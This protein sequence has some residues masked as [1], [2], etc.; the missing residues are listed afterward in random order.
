[1]TAPQA[2]SSPAAASPAAGPVAFP[3]TWVGRAELL[4]AYQMTL[5]DAR[6]EAVKVHAEAYLAHEGP[7]LERD[8]AARLAAAEHRRHADYA[9][10]DLDAYRLLLDVEIRKVWPAG[11]IS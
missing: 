3:S 5:A 7:G 9:Q 2:A 11:E 1:M 10:A 6:A 4:K 8:Q